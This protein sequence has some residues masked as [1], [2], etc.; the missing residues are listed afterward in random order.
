MHQ[1]HHQ[2]QNNW[3]K[4]VLQNIFCRWDKIVLQNIFCRRQQIN[5]NAHVHEREEFGGYDDDDDATGDGV[6]AI[7]IPSS[8]F[9]R[10]RSPAIE[11]KVI[12]VNIVFL[13]S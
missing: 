6:S 8:F 11:V 3:D 13:N 2:T 4:I 5:E 12:A 7:Y 9:D 1:H 10:G